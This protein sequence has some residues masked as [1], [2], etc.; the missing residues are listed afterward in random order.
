M[1][2]FLQK[3]FNILWTVGQRIRNVF[4]AFLHITFDDSHDNMS[5]WHGKHWTWKYI[6]EFKSEANSSMW[7]STAYF[8]LFEIAIYGLQY[9][10]SI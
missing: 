3:H 4:A 10:I 6:F 2:K 5:Q 9:D 1:E 7:G 8:V